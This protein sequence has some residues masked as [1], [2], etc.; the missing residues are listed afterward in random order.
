MYVCR[1]DLL[2][3]LEVSCVE[4][5]VNEIH[6]SCAALTYSR[7]LQAVNCCVPAH[8]LTNALF[9]SCPP[10]IQFQREIAANKKKILKGSK[11]TIEASIDS[12]SR[13]FSDL[14]K[15]RSDSKVWLIYSDKKSETVGKFSKFLYVNAVNLTCQF[16]MPY[17]LKCIADASMFTTLK[18]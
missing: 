4:K 13:R 12:I 2:K 17:D 9:L 6:L 15:V 5:K 16:Q 8:R 14:S 11:N 1:Y 7:Q 3:L 10:L 18:W